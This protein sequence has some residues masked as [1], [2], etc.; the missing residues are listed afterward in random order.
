MLTLF[1]KFCRKLRIEQG[2]LLKEMADKLGVSA[3][4][5]SAVEVGKRN[6]PNDWLDRLSSIYSLNASEQAELLRSIRESQSS[7][8]FELNKMNKSDRDLVMAFAREFK[9]LGD[10][11]RKKLQNIFNKNEGRSSL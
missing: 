6:V 5:L 1:G 4:Y 9:G 8:K 10:E 3:S 11:D 7:I 2:E